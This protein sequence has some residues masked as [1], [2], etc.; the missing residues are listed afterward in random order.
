[1][2]IKDPAERPAIRVDSTGHAAN[3]SMILR[4]R[5]CGGL[6]AFQRLLHAVVDLHHACGWREDARSRNHWASGRNRGRRGSCGIDP[7][8]RCVLGCEERHVVNR[9]PDRSSARQIVS[10]ANNYFVSGPALNV[11]YT[12]ILNVS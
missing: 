11:T 1:M 8:G 10:Q 6:T 12:L 7:R 2:L 5:C 4:V 9:I 3:L